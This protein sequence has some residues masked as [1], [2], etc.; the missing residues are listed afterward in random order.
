MPRAFD[1]S[2][3]YLNSFLIKFPAQ[4]SSH[5]VN[6]AFHAVAAN[7]HVTTPLVRRANYRT[8]FDEVQYIKTQIN[9][10]GTSTAMY[11]AIVKKFIIK[12]C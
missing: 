3:F 2:V 9:V 4:N 10:T 7:Y 8:T 11:Y 5:A 1:A 12:M 6:Q